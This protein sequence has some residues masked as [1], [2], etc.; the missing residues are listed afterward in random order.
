[1]T[2]S[3]LPRLR[4]AEPASAPRRLPALGRPKQTVITGVCMLAGLAAIAG[5]MAMIYLPAGILVAGLELI[6]GSVAYTRGVPRVPT[7]RPRRRRP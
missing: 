5:A 2:P 1:M 6:G 3:E 4:A 7:E